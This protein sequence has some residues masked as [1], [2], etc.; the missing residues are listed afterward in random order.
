MGTALHEH[1]AGFSLRYDGELDAIIA[2]AF[3]VFAARNRLRGSTEH[4]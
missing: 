2:R 3:M 1:N 4:L